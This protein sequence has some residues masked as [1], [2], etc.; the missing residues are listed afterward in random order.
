VNE[1]R[2]ETWFVQFAPFAHGLVRG[3]AL[4][5]SSRGGKAFHEDVFD[6]VSL[7]AVT[8]L[9]QRIA[10]DMAKLGYV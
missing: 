5:I 9:R 6:R 4:L 2:T 1:G 3:D 10:S 8:A 7:H